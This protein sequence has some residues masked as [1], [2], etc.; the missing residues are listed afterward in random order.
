MLRCHSSWLTGVIDF[1]MGS[2]IVFARWVKSGGLAHYQATLRPWFWLLTRKSDCRIFQNKTVPDIIKEVFQDNGFSDFK[3]SLTNE[4]REWENCVQYRETDFN[5]I[6]RLMEQEGIYYF[7]I[8]EDGKHT[9]HLADFI[10]AH[11]SIIDPDVPYYPRSDNANADVDFINDWRITRNLQP[12]AYMYRDFDFKKPKAS[13]D[14]KLINPFEHDY[15]EYEI[16]DYPGE[17]VTA[18]EGSNY[19]AS[20]LEELQVNYEQL[21]GEGNVRTLYSGGLFTLS[22]YPRE[23]QN[24]E[25]LVISASYQ[26]QSGEYESGT[27]GGQD[28]IYTCSFTAIS[29]DTPYRTKRTTPKPI[30]QGPQTAIVVGPSG[31]E[32]WT[33]E[34]GRIKV[35]FHWDRY[36][37]NN[38]NSSCWMRVSQ[39]EAGSGWGAMHLPHV[40]HEVIVS[41]MEGDPDRPIVTGRVYNDVNK[42]ADELPAEH[43]KSV[44][45]S[46]GDNDIVIED[47]EG[48]KFIHIKQACGNEIRMHE[49]EGI[50]IRDRYGNE[51]VM[52]AVEG[53]MKMRSPSHESYII[54]GKS[55]E[56]STESDSTVNVGGDAKK[57]VKGNVEKVILGGEIVNICGPLNAKWDGIS[58]LIHGGLV[59]DTFVGGKH[60]SFVGIQY[61]LNASYKIVRGLSK[62]DKKV[63]GR[64]SAE[65]GTDYL[66]K[67]P[68]TTVFGTGKLALKGGEVEVTGSKITIDV[69]GKVV[70]TGS[71]I[72]LIG[73]VKVSGDLEVTGRIQEPLDKCGMMTSCGHVPVANCLSLERQ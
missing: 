13:M 29:S 36:G 12:G 3:L 59:S 7:F 71:S 72:D 24:R 19:V 22:N 5:F 31:E 35:Q 42:P 55:E 17:Y 54:L 15:S 10:N 6:S 63:A 45:R 2:L 49:V 21:Q 64:V 44:N 39:V 65:A 20:R 47:K 32:I 48:D 30:V 50:Q 40:G 46:F 11:E 27:G 26:L 51:I 70:V 34:Y 52:D 56:R 62:E 14:A 66:V 9:L 4:Y 38:E 53:T 57:K 33:D 73:P 8:H 69:G 28:D 60:G 37:E 41:F 58:A 68:R 61:E 25:Y 23:D 67:A 1:L 16:Y 43:H 18:D